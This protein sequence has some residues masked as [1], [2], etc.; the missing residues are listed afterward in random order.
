[1]SIENWLNCNEA[2][3]LIGCSTDYVAFLARSGAI[4]ARKASERCWLIDQES[5]TQ[6][7]KAPKFTGRPRKKKI[8][9]N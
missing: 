1:M 7:A 5:A 2:A 3:N 6:F 8:E 4:K 9:K